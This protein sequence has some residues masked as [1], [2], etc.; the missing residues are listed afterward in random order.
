MEKLKSWFFLIKC[1]N[2]VPGN[3]PKMGFLFTWNP[4][5]KHGLYPLAN[6]QGV[7]ER[8]LSGET[9]NVGVDFSRKSEYKVGPVL[10]KEWENL[11]L[12]FF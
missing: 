4:P 11:N 12:G 10:T 6:A 9:E 2:L 5:K 3:T 1:A 7:C 8:H